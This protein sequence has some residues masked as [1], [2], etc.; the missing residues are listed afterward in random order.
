M[1]PWIKATIVVVIL[2]SGLFFLWSQW[3]IKL[4]QQASP[5]EGMSKL[6]TLEKDGAVP[7]E[8]IRLPEKSSFKLDEVK[9]KVFILSFW[10]TWCGPCVKEFPSMVKM[11]EHFKGNVVLVGVA[12]DQSPDDVQKFV[13]MFSGEREDFINLWDPSL[14]I[15][16]MYGT[17]K[18]PEN[19][20]FNKKR[21]LVQK[22]VNVEEWNHPQ[23]IHFLQQLVDEK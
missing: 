4:D 5:P 18:L 13:K 21:K 14:R 8:A 16:A 3:K 12:A 10:A 22:F 6:E 19:Y 17:D 7:F 1:S 15:P 2:G 23:M 11:L 20:V 9:D